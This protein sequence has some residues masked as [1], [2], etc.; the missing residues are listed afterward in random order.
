[1]DVADELR[2]R[3]GEG[4][5]QFFMFDKLGRQ[6]RS[7]SDAHYAFWDLPFA[8]VITTNYDFLLESA[9]FSRR[10][11]TLRTSTPTTSAIQLSRGG[12]EPHL[13][14]L[15]GS[16]D[17]LG[18]IVFGRADYRQLNLHNGRLYEYLMRLFI[19]NSVLF[20]GYSL[21]DPDLT[22]LLDNMREAY[23]RSV[24]NCYALVTKETISEFR[25]GRLAKNYN[26]HTIPYD[27]S[28][29]SHPEVLEFLRGLG[30]AVRERGRQEVDT[31]DSAAGEELAGEVQDWL[32][33]IGYEVR[34]QQRVDRRTLRMLA[35]LDRPTQHQTVR[36]YCVDGEISAE[37]VLLARRGGEPERQPGLDFRGQPNLAQR[38]RRSRT[39]WAGRAVHDLGVPRKPG[40]V[41]V[42][43]SDEPQCGSR[44]HRRPLCGL[45][46]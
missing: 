30:R 18:N 10:R 9:Y 26:L 37:D 20:L 4:R 32:E 41:A 38:A 8:S 35:V 40:L 7:P 16:L 23:D 19:Q 34:P 33:S 1:M 24:P 27:P 17:D 31:R 2:E 46:L 43:R 25:G 14:K 42:Y 22:T 11:Q 44:P 21:T 28:D 13:F 15:H 5:F 36:V 12:G 6:A 3:L 29:A 39:K 45:G